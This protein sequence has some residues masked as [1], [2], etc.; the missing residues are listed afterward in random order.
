[1]TMESEN[2]VVIV[3]GDGARLSGVASHV[4]SL[5]YAVVEDPG[6]AP[7]PGPIKTDRIDLILLVSDETSAIVADRIR[8]IKDR[9]PSVPVVPRVR[10][11]DGA[12]AIGMFRAGAWDVLLD[13][14]LPEKIAGTVS[15]AVEIRAKGRERSRMADQL[16]IE[17][18]RAAE[19]RNHYGP[20]DPFGEILHASKAMKDLVNVLREVARSD[21][22][23]LI[24]G[25]SGTGKG[26]A[27]LAIHDGSPRRD[28]PFVEANCVVYSEGVLHSELFGH[29][30]GAFTGALRQK[31]G[32]FE[33]AAGGTIFLDEIGEI[34]PA[35]QLMLLRV[36][37]DQSFERV[38]GER[39]QRS[40]ARV[41]AA[42]NSDLE[43]AIEGGR[44][45][46]DLYYRLHVIPVRMPSLRDRA[47]DIPVLATH[48][49]RR[50]AEAKGSRVTGF[51]A[52]VLSRMADYGWPGNVRELQ[53]VVERLVVLSRGPLVTTDDLPPQIREGAPA[54]ASE[55]AD[56]TLRRLERERI[57]EALG[58]S[59]GNKKRAA[60]LL[61]IHRATLHAKM[62]RHGLR[63]G[64]FDE[65]DGER[66]VDLVPVSD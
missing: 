48:F 24:T 17:R 41:I 22:T 60:A 23:V 52:A 55:R 25:E 43:A 45:R 50:S 47:E 2:G 34:S 38:G 19:I 36:L 11:C 51:E 27:A 30:R 61:G 4:R 65:T 44:F 32:R 64:E 46:R 5:G 12:G 33:L 8:E 59:G 31:H 1:M 56:R 10:A 49:L 29:E 37:Q 58:R 20:T 53:N 16:E 26:L 63:A 14:D 3:L 6:G 54:S 21:A 7:P 13:A 39:T 57:V 9:Y 15:R 42:T 28:G 40:D 18:A 62:R 66:N 35:T